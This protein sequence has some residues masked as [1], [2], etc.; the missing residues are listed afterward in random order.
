MMEQ[1]KEEIEM[2]S[3]DKEDIP[4]LLMY[5]L[6]LNPEIDRN[7]L[8]DSEKCDRLSVNFNR[9]LF[10]GWVKQPSPCCAAAAVAGAWNSLNNLHRTDRRACTYV[11][12]LSIYT[13]MLQ[14]SLDKKQSSFERKLGASLEEYLTVLETE[15]IVIGK[16]LGGKK[17]AAPKRKDIMSI[18]RVWIRAY[19]KTSPPIAAPPIADT[20]SKQ[21]DTPV[22]LSSFTPPNIQNC[23]CDLLKLD[24]NFNL[25]TTNTEDGAKDDGCMDDEEDLKSDEEADEPA[26]VETGLD[27]GASAKAPPKRTTGGKGKGSSKVWDWKRDLVAVIKAKSGVVKITAER[28]STGAIGNWDIMQV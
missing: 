23:F 5:T 10:N 20:D 16:A 6:A 15:L 17:E 8:I 3:L 14:E 22:D 19:F 13:N 21:A 4:N 2:D 28:P 25:E 26:E 7:V 12:V 27:N 18:L 11:E 24:G 9:T 1:P